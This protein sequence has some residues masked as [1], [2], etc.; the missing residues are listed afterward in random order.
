VPSGAIEIDMSNPPPKSTAKGGKSAA[1]DGK[2]RKRGTAKKDAAF[3]AEAA[4]ERHWNCVRLLCRGLDP[5]LMVQDKQG[6]RQPLIELLGIGKDIRRPAG[7]VHCQRYQMSNAINAEQREKAKAERLAYLSAFRDGA[8][9]YLA[10]GWELQEHEDRKAQKRKRDQDEE[11]RRTLY[12]DNPDRR[13]TELNA[14]RSKGLENSRPRPW[15]VAGLT[16]NKAAAPEP[17]GSSADER[18][19][20]G[21]A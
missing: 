18:R 13:E 21:P 2:S 17:A 9:S 8:W 11:E 7:V 1:K 5:A 6:K 3:A 10:K 16:D 19:L 20:A 15:L 12:D 14:L 4:V